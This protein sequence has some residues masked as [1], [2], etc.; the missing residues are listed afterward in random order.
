[1]KRPATN[2]ARLFV[3]LA[4]LILSGTG[5]R[6][7][8]TQKVWQ[9]TPVIS[10]LNGVYDGQLT[11]ADIKTHGDQGL[12][13]WDR[14]NG[15]GVILD[16]KFYRVSAEG[17]VYEQ[18][19]NAVMPFAQVS[20]FQ[21]DTTIRIPP[22]TM[23]SDLGALVDSQLPTINTY[24]ALRL[25]GI[26]ETLETRSL[27]EQGKPY[28]PFWKVQETE[29]KFHFQDVKATMVGFRSP[30]YATNFDP[31]EFHLHCLTADLKG[32]GHVLGFVIKQGV[33]YLQRIDSFET[34]IPTSE[35]FDRADL[36]KID[37]KPGEY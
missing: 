24:Y 8:S 21:A 36:N 23:F 5:C 7:A 9:T 14:L 37:Q 1:M 32:G 12:G 13:T 27:P 2:S 35:A 3:S 4:C 6:S 17:L 26:F 28:R 34:A 15:E 20:F 31:T 19:D 30:P 22:G 33:L 16:G 18:P 10:L 25:E 29:P 11:V